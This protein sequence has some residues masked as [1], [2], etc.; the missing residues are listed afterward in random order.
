MRNTAWAAMNGWSGEGNRRQQIHKEDDFAF[1]QCPEQ[2][3]QQ[4]HMKE[5]DP[6]RCASCQKGLEKS[7]VYPKD[8]RAPEDGQGGRGLNLTPGLGSTF[9]SCVATGKLL[10][11]SGLSFPCLRNG[12][13]NSI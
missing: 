12:V 11:L 13:S 2:S 4:D 8:R 6:V 9:S 10:N 5:T 7:S 3:I 1:D